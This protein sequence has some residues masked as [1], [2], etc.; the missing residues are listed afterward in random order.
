ME[1]SVPMQRTL[2]NQIKPNT[3]EG[4]QVIESKGIQAGQ[5]ALKAQ[6]AAHHIGQVQ[7]HLVITHCAPRAI[8]EHLHAALVCIAPADARQTYKHLLGKQWRGVEEKQEEESGQEAEAQHPGG[9]T[10]SRQRRHRWVSF[11]L[12]HALS[13]LDEQ[14]VGFTVDVLLQGQAG[15][16]QL[17]LGLYQLRTALKEGSV[18]TGALDPQVM[19]GV[20]QHSLPQQ[21][22]TRKQTSNNIT[23]LTVSVLEAT[24]EL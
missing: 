7:I 4:R 5:A 10:V 8:V 16:F 2:S 11:P 20:L 22:G 1:V 3:K 14:R 13:P 21:S 17:G 24:A 9:G 15:L 18:H 12:S 23:V 19:G 6:L